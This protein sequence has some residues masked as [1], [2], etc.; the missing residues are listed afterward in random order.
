MVDLSTL[1]EQLN[2]DVQLRSQFMKDPGPFLKAAGLQV[3]PEQSQKLVETLN[4]FTVR[5][6]PETSA[7]LILIGINGR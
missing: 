6:L 5:Q 3:L 4:S 1:Q 7:S 2:S